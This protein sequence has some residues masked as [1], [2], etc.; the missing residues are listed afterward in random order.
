MLGLRGKIFVG[1]GGLL[2][3]LLASGILAETVV[4][5]ANAVMSQMFSEHYGSVLVCQQ[6]KEIIEPIDVTIRSPRSTP[7][8][9]SA[10]VEGLKSQFEDALGVQ[11]TEITL[12]GELEATN[13]LETRWR[14]YCGRLP[15]QPT[16]RLPATQEKDVDLDRRSYPFSVAVRQAAQNVIDINTRGLRES[17]EKVIAIGN[18][19]T[20]AV[21]MLMLTAALLAIAFAALIGRVILRPIRALTQTVKQFEQGNLELAI[22]VQSKD[23]LG[24][25]SAAMN[26]MA[27]R[28][29]EYRRN[30]RERLLRTERTTQLAIDSLPDAVI[31]VVAP[32]GMIEL[33]NQAAHRLFGPDAR[34]E[35]CRTSLAP[36]LADLSQPHPA[37]RARLG[38]DGY[39]STSRSGTGDGARRFFLAGEAGGDAT[40]LSEG[41]IRSAIGP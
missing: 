36:W 3:V 20:L 11:R 1:F 5:R 12:P 19:V 8:Q 16:A 29:S 2:L 34:H 33:A 26:A 9:Q 13:L 24:T 27:T 25:L 14:D 35:R 4:I 30:D 37:A 40:V 41:P 21:G 17:H 32:A 6:M 28:L 38:T 39:D 23:E 18:R 22:P 15:F 7:D 10:D 31:V